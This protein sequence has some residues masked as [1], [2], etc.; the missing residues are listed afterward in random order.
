MSSAVTVTV[1]AGGFGPPASGSSNAPGGAGGVSSF[2]SFLTANGGLGG[3][4]G[5][6][7]CAMGTTPVGWSAGGAVGAPQGL[8]Q[9]RNSFSSPYFLTR[10]L[11][12]CRCVLRVRVLCALPLDSLSRSRSLLSV[13]ICVSLSLFVS[14]HIS[15]IHRLPIA[16]RNPGGNGGSGG[17]NSNTGGSSGCIIRG[18]GT[19]LLSGY[20]LRQGTSSLLSVLS[21]RCETETPPTP[22][23]K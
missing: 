23:P 3:L 13:S 6:Q 12:F 2:G 8:C 19:A 10:N 18:S 14:L 1:G 5:N 20:T 22:F 16:D 4:G 7:P 21:L 15:F 17:S 9:L 11:T